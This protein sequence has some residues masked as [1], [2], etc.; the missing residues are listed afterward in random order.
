MDSF[1]LTRA[2]V[3]LAVS[4]AMN[5]RLYQFFISGKS[6]SIRLMYFSLSMEEDSR[7]ARDSEVMLLL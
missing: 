5:S 3:A 1:R 2:A 7:T 6:L 4:C